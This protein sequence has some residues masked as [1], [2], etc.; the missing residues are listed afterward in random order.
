MIY[1]PTGN[2]EKYGTVQELEK[3]YER[4]ISLCCN[5]PLDRY[6]PSGKK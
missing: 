3:H 6:Y 2:P 1:K 5:T 4:F